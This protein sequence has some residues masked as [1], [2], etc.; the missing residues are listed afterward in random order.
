MEKLEFNILNNEELTDNYRTIFGDLLVEQ[1]KVQGDCYTK[2]NRCKVICIVL[3][4][5]I[6]IAIGGIKPKTSN[7]FSPEKADIENLSDNFSWELGYLYTKP[8]YSGRGIASNVVRLLLLKHGK[9]SIMASTEISKNPGMVRILTKNGFKQYGKPW[10]SVIHGNF[11]G[12]Y[13]KF[14]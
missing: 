4:N 6:P 9:E 11:L 13:L 10:K 8:E 5:A 7:D 12:L 2:A 1:N 14:I 3:T